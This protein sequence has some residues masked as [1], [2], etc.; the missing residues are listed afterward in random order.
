MFLKKPFHIVAPAVRSPL[1]RVGIRPGLYHYMDESGGAPTRFHLRV[2]S[3]GN[4]LLLANAA[5]A[6]RLRSS[7]VIIAKGLLDGDDEPTLIGRLQAAFRKVSPEQ[8]AADIRRVRG[9]INELKTP[10]DNYPI[11]N[12]ADPAFADEDAPLSTPISADVPL[13]KRRAMRPILERLWE[14]GIPHVTVVAGKDPDARDLIAAVE[15]AEDLG[16]I[17]GVRGHGSDLAEGNRIL[18][19]S[20]AGLD[21]LDVC[22]LSLDD[23]IHDELAGRGDHQN[24]VKAVLTAQKYEVC[25]VAEMALVRPTLETIEETL[26][27][28]VQHGVRNAA[29]FAIAATDPEHTGG[30]VHADELIQAAKLIEEAAEQY[31]VRLLWYPTLRFDPREPLAEQIRRGPR[32]S[33]DSAVR[34]EPDG[35][36]IPARGPYRAAGNLLQ[37]DWET[38]RQGDVFQAYLRRLEADDQCHECPEL[39]MRASDCLRAPGRWADG[40]KDER[41]GYE[42]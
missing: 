33:G 15:R 41:I 26:E 3:T 35:S 16:L 19:L 25:P 23:R 18:D 12:L 1:S 6:A 29:F 2:D 17:T 21:H 37:D 30:A 27:A 14:L 4:G 40:W 8:A 24:A 36:V 31:N 10:E 20:N 38:I 9:V 28:M 5:A 34:V 22:C 13:C 7:G 32:S 11:I 39:V 42:T